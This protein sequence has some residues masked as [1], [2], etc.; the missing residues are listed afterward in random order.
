MEV[1]HTHGAGLDVHKKTVVA[2]VLVLV[3]GNWHQETRMFETMTADLLAL[4]DWLL[5]YKVI[6]LSMEST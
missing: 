4:S 6:H 2:A 1:V 3:N 5:A